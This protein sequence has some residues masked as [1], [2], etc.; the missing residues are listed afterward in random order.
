MVQTHGLGKTH[1]KELHN[2]LP[3]TTLV[4]DRCNG[5]VPR[6]AG[7]GQAASEAAWQGRL[8]RR[9]TDGSCAVPLDDYSCDSPSSSVLMVEGNSEGAD[10]GPASWSTG[11]TS[12]SPQLQAGRGGGE[13]QRGNATL[14]DTPC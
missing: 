8:K 13:L 11:A 1:G 5:H 9:A 6:L 10:K 14:H 3:L 12:D 7:A 2:E 4:G